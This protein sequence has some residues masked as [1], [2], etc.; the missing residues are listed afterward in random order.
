MSKLQDVARKRN[1]YKGRV[2]GLRNNIRGMTDTDALTL[3]EEDELKMC[4]AKLNDLLEN[5]DDR[6][7]EIKE[8]L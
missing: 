8:Y 2:K 4:E 7:E 5:W 6:Y 3:E 1:S